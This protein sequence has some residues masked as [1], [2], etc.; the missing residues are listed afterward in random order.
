[1]LPRDQSALDLDRWSGQERATALRRGDVPLLLEEASC[2]SKGLSSLVTPV[3]Q[4]KNLRE[5]GYRLALMLDQVRAHREPGRLASVA[6]RRFEVALSCKEL[7]PDAAQADLRLDVFRHGPASCELDRGGGFATAS[8]GVE[9]IGESGND[10]GQVRPGSHPLERLVCGTKNPLRGVRVSS[11]QLD[12]ASRTEYTRGEIGLEPE[13]VRSR[14]GFGD[15]LSRLVEPPLH[16]R[17][18]SACL[19]DRH[20][21]PPVVPG[22][23]GDVFD[24]FQRR[25]HRNGAVEQRKSSEAEVLHLLSMV[26]R[27]VRVTSSLLELCGRRP[28]SPSQRR[29]MPT[30]PRARARPPRSSS[31][32]KTRIASSSS[33]LT[34]LWVICA[35]VWR[36]TKARATAASAAT[37]RSPAASASW[38]ASESTALARSGWPRSMS[39][40]PSEGRRPR[41]RPS[42][43]RSRVAARS[44]RFAAAGMSPR[45]KACRPARASR[46]AAFSASFWLRSVGPSS[47]SQRWAC[48]RW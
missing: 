18:V 41:R 31:S 43:G 33:G 14:L 30:R 45:A 20:L 10:A 22:S 32:S 37:P 6:L 40:L 39:A 3:G 13:L 8:L 44:S 23:S 42:S 35:S 34:L 7:R 21:E 5:I 15:Q 16:R 2:L 1:M 12:L 4:A 26:A 36:R 24:A 25:H 48:S 38:I 46:S 27:R 19:Q 17:E 28:A 47:A 29:R 11:K 9:S